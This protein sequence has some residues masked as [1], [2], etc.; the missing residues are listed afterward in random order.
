[1]NK[2]TIIVFFLFMSL[3]V[4]SSFGQQEGSVSQLVDQIKQTKKT[5]IF[6]GEMNK[7]G[8]IEPR[9]TAFLVAIKNIFHLITAKHVVMEFKDGKFTGKFTDNNLLAVFNT[10]DGRIGWRSITEIKKNGLV[11]WVFHQNEHVDIAVIPFPLDPQKDD[12]KVL[13]DTMFVTVDRIFELYD[14]YFLSFQPGIEIQDR[15]I[16][17]IRSGTVSL[18]NKDRT[19]YIDGFAFPGN[20]GSPVF[21]KPSPI[22]FDEKGGISVG[23]DPL[24]GK[25][26][27]VIG[28]YIPYQEVAIST[29][30]MR[31]RVVFE[32]NTG[33]SK[34]WS[35]AF[36]K[37]IVESNPFILQ[38][39]KFLKE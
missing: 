10:K 2:M 9:A 27:G 31:P 18:I 11:N 25:F 24:G 17:V 32:E 8:N 1:M 13:P 38:L 39:K 23:G 33:L 19:F 7:E 35:V 29:Q 14:I 30:T 3:L 21:L 12:V 22:R 4:G 36:I 16:P 5:V 20:S 37:E 6:L 15:I 34:I 26:I 28:E